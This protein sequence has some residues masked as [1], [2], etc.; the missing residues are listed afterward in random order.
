MVRHDTITVI[1]AFIHIGLFVQMED[2]KGHSVG[3]YAWGRI[4][5]EVNL[6]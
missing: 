2:R 6:A 3:N 1:N 5:A 4:V